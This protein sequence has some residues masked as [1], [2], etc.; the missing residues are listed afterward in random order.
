MIDREASGLIEALRL[1]KL[2]ALEYLLL[3]INSDPNKNVAVAIELYEDVYQKNEEGEIYEQDKNYDPTTKFTLNSEE[4]LKSFSS[5]IDIWLYNELSPD[6]KFCF[7]STNN[8]GKESTS[9]RTRRTKVTL[10]KESL[11]LELKSSDPIRIAKVAQIVKDLVFDFYKE[12]YPDEK[13]T[14]DFLSNLQV[15][16][17]CKFLQQISWLFGFPEINEIEQS[18]LRR[19]VGCSYYSSLDNDNQ[20]ETIKAKLMELIEK[21]SITKDRLFK[22]VHKADVELCFKNSVYNFKSLQVDDVHLLWN[23]IDKPT[24]FRNLND[25]I[26][27]VCP[28]FNPERLKHLNRLAAM[29]KVF[30]SSYTNSS[31][32]LA[33]KYRVFTFCESQ[34]FSKTFNKTQIVYTE[35]QIESIIADINSE[36]IEEFEDLK[37]DF[38]YGIERNSIIMELFIEFIDSCY[39]AFD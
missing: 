31:K 18:V 28:S 33:L 12:N 9:G 32:Y 38:T 3:N 23:T 2:R 29:A 17:W 11:L 26:L 10:P 14:I 20:E 30:E 25:K 8:I 1:Q 16:I 39:L 21:K 37:R 35:E 15:E 27:K 22:L 7:L 36:C 24:D 34:L 5:F 19:I 6:I 13:S 4:I